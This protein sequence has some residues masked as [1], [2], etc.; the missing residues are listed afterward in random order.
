[1]TLSSM[2]KISEGSCYTLTADNDC[3]GNVIKLLLEQVILACL[4]SKLGTKKF[5]LCDLHNLVLIQRHNNKGQL[6]TRV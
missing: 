4:I 5:V 6:C 3:Q 1:M 2:N